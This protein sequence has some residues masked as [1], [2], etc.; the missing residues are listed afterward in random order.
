MDNYCVICYV[1]YEIIKDKSRKKINP[2][3]A[4]RIKREKVYIGRSVERHYR[5]KRA[6]K[7]A[8]TRGWGIG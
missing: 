6:D 1:I 8:P 2:P 7:S 4:Q 5:V 3:E